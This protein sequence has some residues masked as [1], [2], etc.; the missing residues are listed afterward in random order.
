MISLSALS[1]NQLRSCSPLQNGWYHGMTKSKAEEA[2]CDEQQNLDYVMQWAN[3]WMMGL[4]GYSVGT[5]QNCS[6]NFGKR[7]RSLYVPRYARS[8]HAAKEIGWHF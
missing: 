4:N 7:K 5:I 6:G 1:D 2:P 8:I 3:A